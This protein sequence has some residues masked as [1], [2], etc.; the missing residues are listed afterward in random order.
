MIRSQTLIPL[1]SG[2]YQARSKIGNFQISENLFAEIN[3]EEAEPDVSVTHY[4][5]EGKR[6]LSAP[7]VA[8]PGR[9]VFTLSNGALYAVVGSTLYYIDPDW[10][11][12]TL[13][14]I[15]GLGGMILSVGLIVTGAGGTPKTY[16]GVALTTT[17]Q[18]QGATADIVVGATGGV[19]SVLVIN[20]GLGFANG[21][22]L[23]AASGDIGGVVGFS[24]TVKGASLADSLLGQQ[25]TTPVSMSDNGPTGVLVDGTPNG[26]TINLVASATFAKNAF[27]PL[28]DQTGLFAGSRRVDFADTFLAFAAPGTN[29]W[30]VSLSDQV[31]FN[32]LVQANKDSTPDPIQ[33]FAFNIRQAWLLGSRN[34]EVWYLAGS[35]PFP[36][37]EWPNIFVPF[38]ISAPYSL[39]RADV[40]LFWISSNA[41]GR[42]IAVM[43]KGYG[44]EAISTR[45]LEYEWSTY[46]TV[47]DV[48]GGTFQQGGHTFIV[49]SFPAAD[50]TWGYDLATKQWHKRTYVD[51]N[52]VVHREKTAFYASVGASGGYR[53]T[54][55]GQDWQTGQ[56]YALDPLFY[57]DNGAPIVF[58]RSFPHIMQDMKEVTHVSFVADFETGGVDGTTD[59]GAGSPWSS[60]FSNAFG[61]IG[62]GV[63][64][65]A[66]PVLC[67]RMSR[68]GGYTWGN[69]RQK[70]F[71]SAGHYRSMMRYRG[72]GMA[73]DSIYELMWAYP[74]PS[75][76]QGAYVEVIPHSA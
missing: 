17:G 43:T 25:V 22:A 57:T 6:P 69:Y 62:T 49:F 65:N 16:K 37:Q 76:L 13:G 60:A 4:P 39:V 23:S 38:G 1:N 48:I 24:T 56:I 11:W 46:P 66:G 75:A 50:V 12:R 40:D 59:V 74:G 34:S 72:L 29:E 41:Q 15:S 19:T 3:P 64:L 9:G 32:P 42:G 26:W 20:P 31:V 70:G 53:E 54:I 61:P 52:G 27:G 10:R 51:Q 2:A 30:Y 71:V 14:S 68:D 63:G 36:Y 58:R 47:A 55:V 28:I 8:G 73:R 21:D 5:R 7:P 44:V 67:M 45:A 18:G 33:T 35:T